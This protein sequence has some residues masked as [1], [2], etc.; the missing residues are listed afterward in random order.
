MEYSS[1][2]V[3][4]YID[5]EIQKINLNYYT[6]INTSSYGFSY[7]HRIIFYYNTSQKR[8]VY[9]VKHASCMKCLFIKSVDNI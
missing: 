7:L 6:D 4:K 8:Y 2:N 1:N 5:H 9:T 3:R